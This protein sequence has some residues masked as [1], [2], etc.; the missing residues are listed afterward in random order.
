MIIIREIRGIYVPQ[1]NQLY[2]NL[3]HKG[4]SDI[5]AML[6]VM[7]VATATIKRWGKLL[8]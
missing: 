8:P 3:L 4:F 6:Q 5:R 7:Y 1:R 2:G